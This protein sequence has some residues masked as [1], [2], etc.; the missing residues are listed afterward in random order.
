M[1]YDWIER[2]LH[3]GA[4][5]LRQRTEERREVGAE[6]MSVAVEDLRRG[7]MPCRDRTSQRGEA[8]GCLRVR[9]RLGAR[10]EQQQREDGS[11]IHAGTIV[12][13]SPR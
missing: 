3:R 2:R 5:G 4:A 6:W 7:G 12:T 11:E 1:L 8:M 13:R 9:R 10:G